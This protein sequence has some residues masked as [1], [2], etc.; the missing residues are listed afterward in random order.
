MSY[1]RYQTDIVEKYSV[2]LIGW[3]ARLLPLKTPS[4]IRVLADLKLLRNALI[5]GSCRWVHLSRPDIQN[6][7]DEH[8]RRAESGEVPAKKRKERSDKGKKC[9]ANKRSKT[10]GSA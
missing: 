4:E 6:R 5:E 8:Q 9:G 2:E 7:I 1:A 3:P 10:S